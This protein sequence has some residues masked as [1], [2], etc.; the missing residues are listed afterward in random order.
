[1]ALA[2]PAS[3]PR[4]EGKGRRFIDQRREGDST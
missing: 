2:P 1:V 4:F 3:L